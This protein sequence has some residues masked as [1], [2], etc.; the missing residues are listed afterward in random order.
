MRRPLLLSAQPKPG[1][2]EQTW[3]KGPEWL[4]NAVIYQIYPSSFKDSDGNGIGDIPGVISKLDYIQSLGVTAIWFQPRVRLRLDRRR[5]RHPG[6][7]PHRPPFG[8]NNDLV[9]LVAEGHE[10]GIKVLLDLVAGH[11][12]DKRP[13]FLQMPRTRTSATPTTSPGATACRTPRPKRTRRR[14]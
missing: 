3:K 2:F 14:C 13:W 1:S 9:E 6:F 7:L 8:T 11:T 4:K 5:L 10:R 12:S